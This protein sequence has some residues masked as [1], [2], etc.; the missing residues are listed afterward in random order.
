[1]VFP[2]PTLIAY[3]SAIYPPLPG[4]LLLPGVPSALASREPPPVLD[5][6]HAVE[7]DVFDYASRISGQNASCASL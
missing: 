4:A 6:F 2:V 5:L 7:V 1:M 3:I